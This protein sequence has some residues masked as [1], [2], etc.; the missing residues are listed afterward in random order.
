MKSYESLIKENINIEHLVEKSTADF[1]K[2][3]RAELEEL[4]DQFLP[5]NSRIESAM[6]DSIEGGKRLRSLSTVL[7]YRMHGGKE[8]DIYKIAAAI[9]LIHCTSLVVDDIIDNRDF[10]PDR[11][12][13]SVQGKYSRME[14][15]GVAWLDILYSTHLLYK[16]TDSL[17]SKTKNQMREKFVKYVTEGG[18]GQLLKWQTT[19]IRELPSKKQ[20][21]DNYLGPTAGLFFQMSAELGALLAQKD[22]K[23]VTE[24]GKLGYKIG[25]LLQAGDDLKDLVDDIRDGFYSLS[26][27]NYYDSLSA[28]EK[29]NF[30][31]KLNFFLREKEIQDIY[32]KL[33]KSKSMTKT[34]KEITIL[35]NEIIR[36]IKKYPDT[37]EKKML[38]SLVIYLK[39]RME[40]KS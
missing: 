15:F 36:Q 5:K 40:I 39:D 37:P 2:F 7:F 14:A 13:A 17:D 35:G 1:E 6:Y 38:I 18:V 23:T 3:V 19:Q 25:L 9:E 22:S 20:Y 26:V 16:A 4:F 21:W 28:K 24:T 29:K 12:I 10:R 8:D 30:K 34:S 27:I 31:S 33:L 11:N 32:L